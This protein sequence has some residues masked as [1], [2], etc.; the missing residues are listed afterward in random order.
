M[1]AK[2][3][4]PPSGHDWGERT[5]QS[6]RHNTAPKYWETDAYEI[7]QCYGIPEFDPQA[8]DHQHP[9]GFPGGYFASA[10]Q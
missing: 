9:A 10:F 7:R 5:K 2:N 6:M 3:G 1:S 8:F 4:T